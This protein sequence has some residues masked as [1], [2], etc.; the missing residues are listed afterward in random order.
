MN[1]AAALRIGRR[2]FGC[3]VETLERRDCPAALSITNVS[4]RE[5]TNASPIAQF[6]VSLS[7]K[8]STA[9]LVNWATAD[10][11][12][13]VADNDYR[14]TSG[15]IFFSPGQ[16]S[17]TVTVYVR[18]DAVV[19]QDE[20][21][22][23]R[24]S[25]AVGATLGQATATATIRNDDVLQLL[26]PSLSISG[27]QRPEGNGGRSESRFTIALSEPTNVAVTV[28]C[29]TVDGTATVA[30]SD[31]TAASWKLVFAPGET[32]KT[33]SVSVLGDSRI[34]SDETFG[35]VLSNP[36]GA[37]IK[38][39][40]GTAT[41]RNDDFPPPTPVLVSVAG[42]SIIEGDDGLGS[43]VFT[44]KLSRMAD[45]VVTVAYRTFDGSA[46]TA[47]SDYQFTDGILSFELGETTKIVVVPVIG[48]AKPEKDE[49][50]SLVLLS[51][52]GASLSRIPA[53]ATL[54]DDDTPPEIRVAN[55]ALTE[56]DAGSSTASFVISLNRSWDQPVVVEYATRD[57]SAT[58]VDFDY[59]SVHGNVTFAPGETQKEVDVLVI[60]DTRAEI[61]EQ[62]ALVVSS[63]TNA[64]I[65]QGTGT[66]TIRN[67][68][69]GEVPGFQITIAYSGTVQQSIQAACDW[70]AQ[71]W[72]EVITGDLPGV[73]DQGGV[74]VDDL[75]ITVREGLLGGWT[76]EP[77]GTLANA[78][79]VV[80]RSGVA[81]LP[82]DA[83]AGIDPYDA[84]NPQLRSIVLHEFG[85][86]LGFGISGTGAP[87]FYR[88]WVG[89][90]G[91]VGPNA[92]REYRSLF[93]EANTAVPLE[94]GGG[95]GTAGSHW[96][97]TV[98]QTELMTGYLSGTAGE[99]APL[100]AITVGAMQ[101]LGYLVNYSA[102]DPYTAPGGGSS[103]SARHASASAGTAPANQS[104]GKAAPLLST[105]AL[106]RRSPTVDAAFQASL[107]TAAQPVDILPQ[108]VDGA[109]ARSPKDRMFVALA[110]RIAHATDG[111][112]ST[113]AWRTLRPA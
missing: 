76:N 1:K 16:K 75:R 56:G 86:A 61:D 10:G 24:L 107:V 13:T 29:A 81:G 74:F 82:W 78:G 31:Y 104:T 109:T 83:Q 23:V 21:F 47:D 77:G 85:H 68:D 72:S 14:P 48:D 105:S 38:N 3:S 98:L 90:D 39:S 54:V 91:F 51:A 103:S 101:D 22:S 34:E 87:T 33:V 15:T 59:V 37:T 57:G 113:L 79:P 8:S 108:S 30:N 32:S 70:A 84:S 50:F 65:V 94:T 112:L 27:I 93:G 46:T 7:Q 28:R 41:I 42:T 40:L 64:T 18:G 95:A 2:G 49:T 73:L 20:F 80:F 35:L 97:D 26:I 66:A 111:P 88:R 53:K 52:V 92:L 6:L 67:D 36:T 43:A 17:K 63:A 58:G 12:A 110:A 100:S 71:R 25:A 19:E 69:S 11:T 60:G 44:F 4:L 45:S 96:R 89:V 55:V 99:A 62:F 5:G 106:S 102:A 9:V